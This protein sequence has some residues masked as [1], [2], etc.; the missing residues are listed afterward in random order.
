MHTSAKLYFDWWRSCI[1]LSLNYRQL[2]LDCLRHGM[3]PWFEHMSSV[4][5]AVSDPVAGVWH[6]LLYQSSMQDF[7]KSMEVRSPLMLVA[8]IGED[9]HRCAGEP[10]NQL[11]TQ[12]IRLTASPAE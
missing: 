3:A 1:A 11:L 4:N 7:C 8:L 12:L 5:P 2:M 9:A 10:S 6:W